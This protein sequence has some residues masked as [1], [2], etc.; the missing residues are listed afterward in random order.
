M[1]VTYTVQKEF[2]NAA[3][4]CIATKAA[5]AN[6]FSL[7]ASPA[8]LTV[9]EGASATAGLACGLL[10]RRPKTMERFDGNKGCG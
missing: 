4:D 9:A 3:N 7:T 8:S 2:S 5:P 10:R 1:A 6:D